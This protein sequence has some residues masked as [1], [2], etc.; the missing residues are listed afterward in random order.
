MTKALPVWLRQS[1][2]KPSEVNMMNSL[3]DELELKTVCQS[4]SCPN[5][6]EC[7]SQKTATFLILGNVCTRNCAFCAVE[8]GQPVIADSDEPQKIAEAV[9]RL[10]LKYVVI[11]SVTRD[12]LPD[13]GAAHFAD[14]IRAVHLL[15]NDVKVEVLIPDFQ[16]SL[17]SLATVV[18]ASP[19]I[20][21]HN[22]ETVPRLYRTVRPK[23]EY[24]RSLDILVQA[25][26]IQPD[27]LTK[28]GIMLGL[29]EKPEEVES[30][31]NDLRETGCD[32]LTIGQYLSPSSRHAPIERYIT[33][34]EFENYALFGENLGFKAVVS[35]PLVRSSHHAFSTYQKIMMKL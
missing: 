28:S 20:L 10:G 12:D 5:L 13:G 30:V 21:G 11:T 9:N 4:A 34:V 16:G 35:G 24:R 23:A 7:F 33:P 1:L 6:G 17:E 29:G 2:S 14:T 22:L 27:I 8:K 15:Q 31:M 32:I 18:R 26:T 19:A 3:L 25:K